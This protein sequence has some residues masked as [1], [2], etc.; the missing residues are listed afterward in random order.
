MKLSIKT[1]PAGMSYV[2]GASSQCIDA[3]R[4]YIAYGDEITK[5][6]LL[7]AS[8]HHCLLLLINEHYHV[9][10]AGGFTSGYSGQG[11]RSLEYVLRLLNELNVDIEEKVVSQELIERAGDA[12]LT[13]DDMAA[14]ESADD[15]IGSYWSDYMDRESP[16]YKANDNLWSYFPTTIP[17]RII[18]RRIL[19]VIQ[20]FEEDPDAALLAGY[21]RLEDIVRKKTE[22]DEHGTKLFSQAF[23]GPNARL[24]WKVKD[25]GE[26]SGRAGLFS[27]AYMAYRNPRAHRES[28]G[29]SHEP[30]VELLLLNTLFLLEAESIQNPDYTSAEAPN[31]SLQARRP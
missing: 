21:R 12:A 16:M 1:T 7:T 10:I 11:P 4:R 13:Y 6:T 30:L 27:N 5:A 29:F 2:I 20:Q 24:T 22:L 31:H 18:D 26:K 14:I 17:Y 8:G 9:A 28:S 19:D 3:V 23:Q 15:P 25:S